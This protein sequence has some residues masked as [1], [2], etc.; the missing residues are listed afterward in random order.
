MVMNKK[1]LYLIQ[2][3]INLY[4]IRISSFLIAIKLLE[5]EQ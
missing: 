2:I 1:L 5:I 4:I 3:L